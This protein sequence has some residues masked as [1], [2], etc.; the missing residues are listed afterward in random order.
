MLWTRSGASLGKEHFSRGRSL[1]A[2]CRSAPVDT[3]R[4]SQFVQG[5]HQLREQRR[6]RFAPEAEVVAG[7]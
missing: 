3:F 1:L 5:G 7:A 4:R 2:Q 6:D